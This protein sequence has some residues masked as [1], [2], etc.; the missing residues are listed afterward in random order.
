MGVH[1]PE[2]GASS[3]SP[4]GSGP[5]N[6]QTEECAVFVKAVLQRGSSCVSET[7][8]VANDVHILIGIHGKAWGMSEATRAQ[9][10]FLDLCL[11]GSDTALLG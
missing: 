9:W 1:F 3:D 8:Q 11:R 7:K 2:E 4:K 5:W 10:N 6:Y